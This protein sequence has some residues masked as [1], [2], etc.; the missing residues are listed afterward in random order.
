MPGDVDLVAT[1][2]VLLGV[3]RTE[4]REV[5]QADIIAPALRAR[6]VR[7]ALDLLGGYHHVTSFFT[8]NQTSRIR[9]V[10]I[11]CG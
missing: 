6:D 4:E 8:R 10:K 7:D 3:V 1:A 9:L 11:P 5:V 2:S